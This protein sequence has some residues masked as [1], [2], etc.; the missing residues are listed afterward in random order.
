MEGILKEVLHQAVAQK[1]PFEYSRE[2]GEFTFARGTFPASTP[3]VIPTIEMDRPYTL[4]EIYYFLLHYKR[5][6]ERYITRA[7]EDRVRSVQYLHREKIFRALL[8]SV[9]PSEFD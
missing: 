1:V 6:L 4:Y 7:R 3:L 2:R 5:P 8:P 9:K